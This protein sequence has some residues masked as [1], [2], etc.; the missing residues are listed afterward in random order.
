MDK[1]LTL[2]QQQHLLALVERARAAQA[3]INQFVE[4]LRDE[5]DAPEA[6]GWALDDVQV[7]FA[8]R[9]QPTPQARSPVVPGGLERE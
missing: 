8:Q 3:A 6:N 9:P 7:G 2:S 5:H 4:Y 1:R